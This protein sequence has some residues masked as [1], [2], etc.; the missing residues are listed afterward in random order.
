LP[1]PKAR[2]IVAES[3]N[4]AVALKVAREV[5]A[6]GLVFKRNADRIVVDP[7]DA[8]IAALKLEQAQNMTAFRLRFVK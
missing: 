3:S 7:E 8:L 2:P 4:E 6:L 1:L 5:G